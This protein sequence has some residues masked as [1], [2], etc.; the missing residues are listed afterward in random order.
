MN[1]FWSRV[2]AAIA[3]LGGTLPASAQPAPTPESGLIGSNLAEARKNCDL[4][5]F[6]H[7]EPTGTS[8]PSNGMQVTSFKP[9]GG[10]FRALV[11]L[12]IQTDFAG[13]IHAANLEVLHSFIDSPPNGIYAA[14]LVKSFL[15]DGAATSPGDPVGSLASEISSRTMERSG[16]RIITAQPLPSTPGPPTPAYQTYTGDTRPATL[17]YA[18]GQRQVVLNNIERADVAILEIVISEKK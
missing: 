13:I 14:D 17:L 3:C 2:G 5:T 4:F 18:S 10:T 15:L 11:T 16:A 12:H 9:S 7:F 6:F 8:T 1:G